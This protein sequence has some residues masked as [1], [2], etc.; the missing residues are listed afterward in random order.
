M[1]DLMKRLLGVQEQG[2]TPNDEKTRHRRAL[3]ATIAL[4][5]EMA[6]IDGEFSE[7]ERQRIVSILKSD[8]GLRASEIE[9]IMKAAEKEV[10]ESIDLWQF[11]SLINQYYSEDEKV[12]II[13]TVWRVI[14][15]DG[16]LD[17][18]EDYLVHNLADLLRLDHSQLIDAKLKAKEIIEGARA[19]PG[20]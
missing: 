13:E 18:H 12:R 7:D 2:K 17:K 14:F 20:E 9:A 4:L 8:Y 15:T 16:R 10:E 1:I 11:T 6:H 3:V 19:M 5:F